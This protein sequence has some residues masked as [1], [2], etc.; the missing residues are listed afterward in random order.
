MSSSPSPSPCSAGSDYSTEYFQD[1]VSQQMSV[2]GSPLEDGLIPREALAYCPKPSDILKAR[3]M[4]LV[5]TQPNPGSHPTRLIFG[6]LDLIPQELEGLREVRKLMARDEDLHSSPIFADDRYAIRFLQGNDWDASRC[7]VDMKRHLQWRSQNLPI[8]RSAVEP[9]LGEVMPVVIY[10][11]EFTLAKLLV[12]N[13]VE[14]WR[15][16]I[17]LEDCS[18][19]S[20]PIGILKHVCDTLTEEFLSAISRNQIEERYGGTCPNVKNFS[21]PV[22]PPGPYGSPLRT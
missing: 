6:D 15:V 12:K 17:D 13:K 2:E 16:I 19:T 20:A 9:A 8:Q 21:W 22:M 4:R 11:L 14:Q 10:W 18:I 1:A 7:I 5:S 3:H